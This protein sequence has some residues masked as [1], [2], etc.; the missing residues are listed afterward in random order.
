[1]ATPLVASMVAL[2][3]CVKPNI[4]VDEVYRLWS[5]GPDRQAGQEPKKINFD[6]FYR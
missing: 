1:M 6:L 2:I 4:Q 5:Y 3:K